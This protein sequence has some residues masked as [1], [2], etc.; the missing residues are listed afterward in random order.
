MKKIF[1]IIGFLFLI[2]CSSKEEQASEKSQPQ[3]EQEAPALNLRPIEELGNQETQKDPVRKPSH[4]KVG[5]VYDMQK[6]S[7][8]M[9]DVRH[10][11]DSISRSRRK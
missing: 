10:A 2:S 11:M 8:F 9:R 5:V 3:K 6:D 7:S 4:L 1:L